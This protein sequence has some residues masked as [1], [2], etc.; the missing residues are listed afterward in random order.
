MNTN[1]ESTTTHSEMYADDD[2][3]TRNTELQGNAEIEDQSGQV[4]DNEDA[5]FVSELGWLTAASVTIASVAMSIG[6]S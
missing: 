5:K 3:A 1:R 6:A 2:E 4:E